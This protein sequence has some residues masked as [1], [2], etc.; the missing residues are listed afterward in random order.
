MAWIAI[1]RVS[2]IW[3]PVKFRTVYSDFSKYKLVACLWF[4]PLIYTVVIG[5]V[6]GMIQENHFAV[7]ANV[8]IAIALSCLTMAMP[9]GMSKKAMTVRFYPNSISQQLEYLQKQFEP[10]EK[11]KQQY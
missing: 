4:L 6:K 5:V 7:Y 1:E 10:L 11:E 2:A 9:F 3:R 8:S